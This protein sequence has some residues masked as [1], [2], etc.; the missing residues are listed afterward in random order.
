MR[1]GHFSRQF[2]CCDCVLTAYGRKIVEELIQRISAL[3]VVEQVFHRHSRA[4][5]N[6]SSAENLWIAMNNCGFD[7]HR[8]SCTVSIRSSHP[9]R[10]AP[11]ATGIACA[12]TVT[13]RRA[14]P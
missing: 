11:Y 1:L 2:K 8:D 14:P 9:H 3:K 12:E 4:H 6:W 7:R 5:E 13:A 10:A